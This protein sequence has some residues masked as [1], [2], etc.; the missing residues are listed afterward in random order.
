M[1]EAENSYQYVNVRDFDGDLCLGSVHCLRF[2][3]LLSELNF[4]H[5]S[6][7]YVVI[8]VC[9]DELLILFDGIY[10]HLLETK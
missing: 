4:I 2:F 7:F 10:Q 8:Y 1:S 3:Q 5:F 9:F 6:H